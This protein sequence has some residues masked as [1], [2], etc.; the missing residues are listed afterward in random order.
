V[1][2]Q[3][4]G[5]AQSSRGVTAMKTPT[6]E[7]IESFRTCS[8]DDLY[9]KIGEALLGR[10]AMPLPAKRL[11][12][13]GKYWIG[14]NWTSLAAVVC[15]DAKVKRFSSQDVYSHELVVAVTGA[16]DLGIHLVGGAPAVTVAALIVRLGIHSLCKECW[17]KPANPSKED[18]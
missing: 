14:K 3:L 9:H 6:H 2:A 17:A 7:E 5:R 18:S 16:I 12:E 8:E 13:A 11:I 10:Q 15:A 1:I 4:V